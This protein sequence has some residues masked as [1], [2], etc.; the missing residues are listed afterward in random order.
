MFDGALSKFC[1]QI[2][3]ERTMFLNILL[4]GESYAQQHAART[5]HN[6]NRSLS[7]DF[8]NLGRESVPEVT[9]DTREAASLAYNNL[10]VLDPAKRSTT[11]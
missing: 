11:N 9:T 5:P 8:K 10:N 2:G 3:V 4:H 1:E 7:E 6:G